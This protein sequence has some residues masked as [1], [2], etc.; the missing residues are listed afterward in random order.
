MSAVQP[1]D[2][3]VTARQLN[4]AAIHLLRGL[5]SAD[6]LSGLTPARLSALSVLV[7]GGPVPL[8]R[9]ATTEGVTSPTMTRIVDGLTGLG[10]AV[11]S[12]HPDSARLVVVSATESGRELMQAAA[13]RRL[14]RIVAAL[15]D[16]TPAERDR[17]REAAPVLVR[18]STL[19]R[20]HR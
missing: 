5:R 11:R 20:D 19:V 1:P 8:G 4:S 16:L 7:F 12:V 14:D 6:K 9:L 10:L 15:D 3:R 18:L 17:V 2:D 13:E